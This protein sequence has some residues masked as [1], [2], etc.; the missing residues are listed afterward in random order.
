MA[1]VH[2]DFYSQSL[3]G[4][5]ELYAVLPNDVPPFMAEVNEHYKRPAKVLVLLHGYSGNAADWVTGSRIRELSQEYNLAVLMPNG[6]NSFYLDL[7]GTGEQYASYVGKELLQYASRAFGLDVSPENCIIGGLSMGGFGAIHTGLQFDSYKKVIGLSSAL[8]VNGLP[9]ITD[10]GNKVANRAY[11]EHIF[12]DLKNAPETEASPEVLV[13]KRILAGR[14]L[15][16]FFLACGS[17][18]FLIEAN[19]SLDAFLTEQGVKHE[20][21][22]SP[23]IHNWKFWNEWLEPA[24]VWALS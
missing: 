11:Y 3:S 13:K 1:L 21:H 8:I 18:D 2:V 10:E 5:T 9:E 17:E 20:F 6:R 22:V 12:G 14:P 7:E 24:I 16:E 4:Q 19:R 23:G 15:P